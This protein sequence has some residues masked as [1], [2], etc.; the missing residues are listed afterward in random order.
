MRRCSI[1][2][3]VPLL[4]HSPL[5]E[6]PRSLS[7]G[8]PGLGP[9]AA[10]ATRIPPGHP[11]GYLEGFA[12]LYRDSAEQ[13]E[14]HILGRPADPAALLVPTVTD[15]VDGMRFIARALESADA[16]GAWTAF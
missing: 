10:R 1:A 7:R 9:A 6:A 14:A 16:D 12:Q 11:E 2:S 8:G 15:G 13:I 5:G 4:I 3:L